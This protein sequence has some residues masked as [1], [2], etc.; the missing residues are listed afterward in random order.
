MYFNVQEKGGKKKWNRVEGFLQFPR[1]AASVILVK[2]E[3]RLGRVAHL[4]NVCCTNMNYE[5][6]FSFSFSIELSEVLWQMVMRVGLRVDTTYGVLL[7]VPV[8][9]FFAA[10]TVF[11]LL[12]MEGLSAF[13]HAIRL[14]WQVLTPHFLIT[15]LQCM[16]SA[17]AGFGVKILGAL[18]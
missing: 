9:A 14:H 6:C 4:M 7:L 8:L 11:I 17:L 10:L 18:N 13:L 15:S 16:L 12:V 2:P 3:Y 5:S 1:S